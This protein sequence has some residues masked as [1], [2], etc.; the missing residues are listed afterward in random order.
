[1][2]LTRITLQ[3]VDNYIE[4]INRAEDLDQIFSILQKQINVLGFEKMTYWL[5]W[6]R[7]DTRRPVLISSYPE[8]FLDHYADQNFQNH[9]MVGKYSNLKNTPFTWSDIYKNFEVTKVQ[10]ILFQDSSSVG[11]RSGGS[12][13]IHGPGLVKAT[14]SV[15][16]D[17]KDTTFDRLFSYR[18][19]ELQIIATYAHEK[20][21]SLG[22]DSPMIDNILTPKEIDIL[23]WV[24]AGKSYWEI[25]VI[26]KIQEDT[27]KKHMQSIF[28]KLGVTNKSHAVSKAIIHGI[29]F[30]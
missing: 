3:E 10:K 16:N 21:M 8:K 15:A 28:H 12:I 18:R 13:P 6:H 26:H 22:L 1:M 24:A 25:G 4:A 19:H 20:I 23:S 7:K 27:V 2:A 17:E 11:L 9:D 30:P 29:I 5:R 14:F